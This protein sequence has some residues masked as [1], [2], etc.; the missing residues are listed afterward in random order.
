[1]YK[2]T[3]IYGYFTCFC[4]R[5]RVGVLAL[6]LP[7]Q[8]EPAKKNSTIYYC[9][10]CRDHI[11]PPAAGHVFLEILISEGYVFRVR[12]PTMISYCPGYLLTFSCSAW[13]LSLP[14]VFENHIVEIE[15]D[16]KEAQLTLWDTS[17]LEEYD[18]LRP[19]AYPDSHVTSSS[20]ASLL[21]HPIRSTTSRRRCV[22]NLK[23]CGSC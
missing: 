13:Q 23:V 20:S 11:R 8:T 5:T 18:R 7:L 16:G 22:T 15:V 4:K 17:D 2:N 12:F 19:L 21:T 9:G 10:K 14:T 3:L 6:P 1:M